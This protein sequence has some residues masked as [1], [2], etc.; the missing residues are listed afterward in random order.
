M[1]DPKPHIHQ[2]I[3]HELLNGEPP[4]ELANDTNLLAGGLVD[5]LGMVRLLA[6]LQET[7]GIGI[8]PEDVTIE[9]FMTIDVMADYVTTRME[10]TP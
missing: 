10:T 5:S 9:N 3:L 7:F 6:N 2:F 8:P 1:P 4:E